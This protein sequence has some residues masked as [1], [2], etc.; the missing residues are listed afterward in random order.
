MYI[1]YRHLYAQTL[2]CMH[3]FILVPLI[4]SLIPS[5]KYYINIANKSPILLNQDH[6]G[7]LI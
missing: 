1:D 3:Y 5:P 2:I 6:R 4:H 7:V